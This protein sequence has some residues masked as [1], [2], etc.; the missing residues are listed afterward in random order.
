MPKT[1][2]ELELMVFRREAE[3]AIQSKLDEEAKASG[4]HSIISACSYTGSVNFGAEAQSLLNWRD[5]VWTYAF[6]VESDILSGARTLP[7]LDELIAE[8]PARV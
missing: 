6:Q 4:Y 1:Q 2:Q 8:L 5:A 7:T 3:I